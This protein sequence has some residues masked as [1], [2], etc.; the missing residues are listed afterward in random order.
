VALPD[1]EKTAAGDDAD[2]AKIAKQSIAKI[3]G[4]KEGI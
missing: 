3:S 4:K 2:L 1:L